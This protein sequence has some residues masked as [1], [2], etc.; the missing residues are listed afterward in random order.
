MIWCYKY[1]SRYILPVFM[2]PGFLFNHI[3]KDN[4]MNTANPKIKRFR[5]EFKSTN[6]KLETP[7]ALIMPSRKKEV[8]ENNEKLSLFV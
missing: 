1:F 5:E 4:P 6:C 2:N 8:N 3:G 7:T